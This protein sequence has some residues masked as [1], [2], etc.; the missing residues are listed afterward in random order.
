VL[1]RLASDERTW[2]SEAL[3]AIDPEHAWLAKLT[4]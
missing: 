1:P 3:S 4:I 2:L